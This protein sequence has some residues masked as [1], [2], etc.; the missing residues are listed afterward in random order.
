MVLLLSELSGVD[1]TAVPAGSKAR[2]MRVT[3]AMVCQSA[4]VNTP[5]ARE[6]GWPRPR[7]LIRA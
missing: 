4:S 6:S 7:Q 3:G 5:L 2:Q 1:V